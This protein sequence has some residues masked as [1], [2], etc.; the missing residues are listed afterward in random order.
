MLVLNRLSN[1]FN[2]IKRQ[3]SPMWYT[4]SSVVLLHPTRDNNILIWTLY[5]LGF[6][7]GSGG[8]WSL[9]LDQVGEQ[10]AMALL[11]HVV[12]DIT[13]IMCEV[14][15]SSQGFYHYSTIYL[16]FFRASYN[17]GCVNKPLIPLWSFILTFIPVFWQIIPVRLQGKIHFF[18]PFFLYNRMSLCPEVNLKRT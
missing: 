14:F 8:P 7:P 10:I 4:C 17:K 16:T 5:N 2:I 13:H 11:S 15:K 1:G 12:Q 9:L 3:S 18:I 6:L